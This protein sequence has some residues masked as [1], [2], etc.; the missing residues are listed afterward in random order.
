[1]S[2]SEKVGL[3]PGVVGCCSSKILKVGNGR[4][5]GPDARREDVV[6]TAEGCVEEGEG[7]TMASGRGPRSGSLLL[8]DSGTEGVDA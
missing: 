5:G 2:H 1:V 3:P 6:A 8:T 7:A 4:K